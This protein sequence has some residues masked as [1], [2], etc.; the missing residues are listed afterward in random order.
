M[1]PYKWKWS[2]YRVK[3]NQGKNKK[4]PIQ[5]EIKF[6]PKDKEKLLVCAIFQTNRMKSDDGEG[7][8][9]QID[10]NHPCAWR[11]IHPCE[12]NMKITTVAGKSCTNYSF[13]RTKKEKE[14]MV[15]TRHDDFRVSVLSWRRRGAYGVKLCLVFVVVDLSIWSPSI[16][17]YIHVLGFFAKEKKGLCR[18]KG[19]GLG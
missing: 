7:G 18:V 9:G 4:I 2:I 16:V 1:N 6:F 8:G 12:S 15:W 3:T 19:C 5:F 17:M 14:T 10:S 13:V 11:G